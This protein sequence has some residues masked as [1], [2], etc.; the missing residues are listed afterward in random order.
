MCTNVCV[1][2]GVC[3]C[4]CELVYLL[5][6][7]QGIIVPHMILTNVRSYILYNEE[8]GCYKVVISVK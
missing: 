2:M 3:A 5:G 7:S 8:H 1:G 6:V 4:V